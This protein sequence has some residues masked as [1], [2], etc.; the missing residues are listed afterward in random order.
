MKHDGMTQSD[1]TALAKALREIRA[2]GMKALR[3]RGGAKAGQPAK[4]PPKG[5]P[6][7]EKQLGT[8]PTR[9]VAAL[10][11]CEPQTVYSRYTGEE[12]AALRRKHGKRK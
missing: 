2:A 10:Y 8:M 12:L 9:D 5:D 3:E 6:K 4:M 7:L 1:R 11:K